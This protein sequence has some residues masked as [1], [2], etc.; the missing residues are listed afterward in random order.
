MNLQEF[1]K[2]PYK[3]QLDILTDIGL[4]LTQRSSLNYSITLFKVADFYVEA[5]FDKLK[6][7]MAYLCVY[8]AET[9][10]ECYCEECLNP[11]PAPPDKIQVNEPG[12]ISPFQR[13]NQY[14]LIDPD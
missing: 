14:R 3:N 8:N 4:R 10:P 12:S 5:Y 9:L 2:L 7:R 1:V 13:H 6:F 11:V